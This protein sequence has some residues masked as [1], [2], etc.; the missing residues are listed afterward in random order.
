M[1]K[2]DLTGKAQTVLGPIEPE[3]LGITLTHEHL[4]IDLTGVFIPPETASEIGLSRQPVSLENLWWIQYH[5]A[6]NL[7]NQLLTDEDTAIQEALRYKRA[8]G[9]TMV[10]A[11][12]IGIKRDPKGLARI[13]RATGLNIIM[14]AG[15]YVDKCHPPDVAHKSEDEIVEEIVTDV[16][17]GVG[18]TGIK[19]GIIGEVGCSW[20]LTDNERKSLRAA[21]RAQH[22]TG[23]PLLVHPGR[24]P[25]APLEIMEII[26]EVGGDPRRTVMSHIDRTIS[27]HETLSKLAETGCYLNYDNFGL[28]TAIYP[29]GPIDMLNDGRRIDDILYLVDQGCLEQVLVSHD[30]CMK[31]SLTKYGGSGYAHILENVVPMMRRKGLSWEQV[32]TILVENPKRILTFA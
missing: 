7:D 17:E 27:Q 20:P 18:D 9:T 14:G 24:N 32:N 3:A 10:D 4:L 5:W 29:M 8:G 6:S 26:R 15:Y 13:A 2:N 25:E 19:A 22:L 23:A 21:A 16:M 11:T 30:V 31:I 28:E 1:N 12:S